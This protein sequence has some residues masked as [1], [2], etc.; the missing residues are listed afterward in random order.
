[1]YNIGVSPQGFDPHTQTDYRLVTRSK[2]FHMTSGK[3]VL[4]ASD[5]AKLSAVK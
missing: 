4:F 2:R 3:T 1:M 5:V